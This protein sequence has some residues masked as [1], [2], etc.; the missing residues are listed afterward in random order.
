MAEGGV[1]G[2]LG[3]AV[4]KARSKAAKIKAVLQEKE[5]RVHTYPASA[6]EQYVLKMIEEAKRVRLATLEAFEPIWTKEILF[7][8]G[9]QHLRFVS[10]SRQFEPAR[11]EDWMPLPVFNHIQPKVQRIIDFF[12]RNKPGAFVEANSKKETD[13]QAAEVADMVR[14]H[15]WDLNDEDMNYDEAATWMVITGNVFKKTYIDTSLKKRVR[16][17]KFNVTEDPI[18]DSMNQMIPGPDGLPVTTPRYEIM[19][20][21]MGGIVYEEVPQGEVSTYCCGPMSMTVPLS[22]VK[23]EDAPWI[24]ETSLQDLEFIR[25]MFPDKAEH[26]GDSGRVITSD[27]YQHRLTSLLTSGLHGVVRSLDPYTLEGYGIV[28]YYERQPEPAFPNGLTVIELDGIPLHVGDLALGNEYSYEHAGYFRVP[29]R[30]WYRSAVEDLLHPQEQINK[31]EQ[32]FQ[33]NDAFMSNPQWVCP[34][35]AGIAE[36]AFG[37]R[38]GRVYR[39]QFPYKPERVRGESLPPQMQQRRMIYAE[40]MD[41]ISNIRDVITGGAPPGVTAGVALNL[42]SEQ[43]E[44]SFAPIEKRYKRFIER[45]QTKKLKL[46]QRFYSLPRYISVRKEGTFTEIVDFMG[47]QLQGNT[48]V[49]VEQGSYR[50]RSKAG[51]LQAM[52]DA[53]DRGLLQGVYTDPDQTQR[54]LAKMGISEFESAQGLDAKRARW[55]N[56]MLVRSTGFEQVVRMAGDDDYIHLMHHTNYRK[57][58]DFLRLPKTAQDRVLMHEISHIEA[59]IQAQ[60]QPDVS[61]GDPGDEVQEEG[62][63]PAQDGEGGEPGPGGNGEQQPQPGA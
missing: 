45:D 33:L 4:Q 10:A 56:E 62:T 17:P 2:M 59:I 63:D 49:R 16:V 40:D 37:N 19:R 3:D 25:Q 51:Q 48:R 20:D 21:E 8:A 61:K 11:R 47:A 58:H 23:L 9:I 54:F 29:G 42:L 35:E 41:R 39:Y 31:L 46:V 36:S 13:R 24:M 34:D 44:G 50:A 53:L 12:T 43:A 22:T 32:F 30:F 38:P 15:L 6:E 55:E 60:G 18:T 57:T 52:I 7:C 14:E 28:H 26:I 27:L 5:K 1:M